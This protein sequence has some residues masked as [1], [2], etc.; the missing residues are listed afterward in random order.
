M[1]VRQGRMLMS[2]HMRETWS[3]G[4]RDSDRNRW[5]VRRGICD[6]REVV[7]LYLGE[8]RIIVELE[9]EPMFAMVNDYD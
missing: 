4:I 5:L 6:L 9:L 7:L 8:S 2:R 3:S 1:K